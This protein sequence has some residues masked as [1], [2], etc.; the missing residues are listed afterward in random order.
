M[1]RISIKAVLSFVQLGS[2]LLSGCSQNAVPLNTASSSVDTSS[3]TT[4]E[5]TTT[6]TSYN[7]ADYQFSW[8]FDE[9]EAFEKV[10]HDKFNLSIAK[11][12]CYYGF[13]DDLNK[14]YTDFINS[15]F[16]TDY[17]DVPFKKCNYFFNY[18]NRDYDVRHRFDDY[19][20]F[21]RKCFNAEDACLSTFNNKLILSYLAQNNIPLGETIPIENF[22]SLM[23]DELYKYEGGSKLL[24]KYPKLGNFDNTYKYNKHELLELLQRYNTI[25]Y[26]LCVDNSI[27]TPNLFEKPEVIEIYNSH[28]KEFYGIDIKMG[29]VLT[30]EQYKAMFGEDPLDLSYIPGAVVK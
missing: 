14:V 15:R 24:I 12:I 26:G 27:K 29:E 9:N 19:E 10:M 13:T 25:L 28:L 22:K 20:K 2:L 7:A 17:K 6:T 23:G 30:K 4:V 11:Y 3:T 1:K 16:G 18:I 8:E 21:K 5:V